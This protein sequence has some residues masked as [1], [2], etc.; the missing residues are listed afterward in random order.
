MMTIKISKMIYFIIHFLK[1]QRKYF[2]TWLVVNFIIQQCLTV[3]NSPFDNFTKLI[4]LI[5][6]RMYKTHINGAKFWPIRITKIMASHLNRRLL[7]F[8]LLFSLLNIFGR[9]RVSIWRPR[10]RLRDCYNFFLNF[11]CYCC[12][13]S[14]FENSKFEIW[15]KLELFFSRTGFYED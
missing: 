11:S 9:F 13:G 1:L 2:L 15:K 14:N 5:D 3:S 4:T 7:L 12:Q 8:I 6:W 10:F